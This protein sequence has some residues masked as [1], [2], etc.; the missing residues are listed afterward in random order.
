[1]ITITQHTYSNDKRDAGKI[2]N[3]LTRVSEWPQWD[4]GGGEDLRERN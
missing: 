1:M 3:I 2:W 4:D